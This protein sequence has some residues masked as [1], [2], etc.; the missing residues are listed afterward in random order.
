VLGRAQLRD[1]TLERVPRHRADAERR[2]QLAQ[3]VV[4]RHVAVL[5]VVAVRPDLLVDEV[6]HRAPDHLELFWPFEH[7]CLQP[8]VGPEQYVYAAVVTIRANG[9]GRMATS[10]P[11]SPAD[12][13]DD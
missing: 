6:A 11:Q 1:P 10:R 4:R 13:A 2:V 7:H 8:L 9:C 3:Q 12:F 5:E